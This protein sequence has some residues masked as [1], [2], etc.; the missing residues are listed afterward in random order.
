M[1][2]HN[3]V[4]LL[5]SSLRLFA[6]WGTAI[7]LILAVV[8]PCVRSLG[9]SYGAGAGRPILA[10]DH[11]CVVAQAGLDPPLEGRALPD[12]LRTGIATR[13]GYCGWTVDHVGWVV[14]LLS[15]EEQTFSGPTLEEAL[16]W[17]LV[18]LM[19]PEMGISQFG[20]RD[21]EER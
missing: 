3:A 6:R 2:R 13:R 12:A 8:Q 1:D 11:A 20:V 10:P 5:T 14:T 4:P 21:A 18:W 16:A 9:S 19:A 15:P 17:C 7:E